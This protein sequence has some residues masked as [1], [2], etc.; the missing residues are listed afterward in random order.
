M[1]KVVG[2]VTSVMV[3]FAVSSSEAVKPLRL[4]EPPFYGGEILVGEPYESQ[5]SKRFYDFRVLDSTSWLRVDQQGNLSGTPEEE[6]LQ[7]ILVEMKTRQHEAIE[8][9]LYITVHPPLTEGAYFVA[10]D[11]DDANSG[12]IDEPF[13]TVEHGIHSIINGGGTLYLREGRYHEEITL[14]G[15][16]NSPHHDPQ[17]HPHKVKRTEMKYIES[18][19]GET[20]VFDGTKGIEELADGEWELHEG[21]IY[22]I[23]LN[24]DIWQLI[25][26]DAVQTSAR[27][28]NAFW[29]DGSIW[30]QNYWGCAEDGTTWKNVGDNTK[31]E[32]Y[33]EDNDTISMICKPSPGGLDSYPLKP[34]QSRPQLDLA[35]SGIDLT[36]A[37]AILNIANFD[38]ICERVI[39]HAAGTNAFSCT[40]NTNNKWWRG[41][42][43]TSSIY[44]RYFFEGTLALLDAP[45]EWFYDKDSQWLYLWTQDGQTPAGKHI[46]GKV[47]DRFLDTLA[48]TDLKLKGITFKGT[49]V[50]ARTTVNFTLSDCDFLYPSYSQRMLGKKDA[51]RPTDISGGGSYVNGQITVENCTF[52]YTDGDGVK[53]AGRDNVIENCLFYQ[54]DYS[55]VDVSSG[56]TK[57]QRIGNDGTVAV[58][59]SPG[60]VQ[61]RI[62]A[63]TCGNGHTL[64][65]AEWRG[66]ENSNIISTIEYCHTKNCGLLH[67]QDGANYQIWQ[68]NTHG[69]KLRYNWAHDTTKFG[70]RYDGFYELRNKDG[71]WVDIKPDYTKE[72]LT[73]H[74]VAWNTYRENVLDSKGIKRLRG[75]SAFKIDGRGHDTFNNTALNAAANHSREL[76]MHGT[77]LVIRNNF[78]DRITDR[79]GNVIVADYGHNYTGVVPNS[80]AKTEADHM[81][82]LLRDPDHMDFRPKGDSPLVDAGVS[83][84]H[85]NHMTGEIINTSAGFVGSAPDIGAYE[86]GDDHYW[87]PGYQAPAASSPIPPN[88]A[89]AKRDCDLMW[90][91]GYKGISADIYVHQDKRSVE[92]AYR[93]SAAFK[94]TFDDSKNVF[95]PGTLVDGRTYYWRVDTRTPTRFAKGDVWEV[96]AEGTQDK[97]AQ[98]ANGIP[99]QWLDRYFKDPVSVEDYEH[100]STQDSDGDGITNLNAF[101]TGTSPLLKKGKRIRIKSFKMN[102]KRAQLNWESAL[103]KTYSIWTNSTLSNPS[104]GLKTNGIKGIN[105]DLFFS[106]DEDGEQLFFKVDVE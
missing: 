22:K 32:F 58:R 36:G 96:I 41:P 19:P 33:D 98:T 5:F 3:F 35:A 39:K 21:K 14:K 55:C 29:H 77:N 69:I 12:L 104:W 79:S 68:F 102:G 51:A 83:I 66:E 74:C 101:R 49:T 1:S 84:I 17:G 82:S 4:D 62:T 59:F 26:D 34:G 78:A 97:T 92:N 11:G 54:V 60:I 9:H 10:M 40:Y 88:H 20:V 16:M 70:F 48:V 73:D 76:G 106:S 72:G 71:V 30:D 52:R 37:M 80:M 81:R 105:G 100:L 7:D 27:W 87:I 6:G 95:T 99:Y 13:R 47:Q 103:D 63:D 65:S 43:P 50:Q 23:K 15:E 25:V 8:A 91:K 42:N 93:G 53:L 56:Q 18:Y 64:M 46:R 90:L 38:T 61:R 44:Q 94:G 85:T 24:Q 31:P 28:P 89:V 57:K 75:N 67:S 2:I 86:Y 45:T